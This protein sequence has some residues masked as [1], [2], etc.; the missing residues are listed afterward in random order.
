MTSVEIEYCV[1]CGMLDRAQD[2]QGT[3]LDQYGQRLDAVSLV[4]GDGGVFRVDVDGETVYD[5]GDEEY[6]VETITDRVGERVSAT[7]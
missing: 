7:A 2:L 1:P 3:L 4:T 5:K 6:D